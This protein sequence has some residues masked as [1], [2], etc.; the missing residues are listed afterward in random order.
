[1]NDAVGEVSRARPG[2]LRPIGDD[3]IDALRAGSDDFLTTMTV[4][5]ER[6]YLDIEV[7]CN[8]HVNA[9][10]GGEALA[11]PERLVELFLARYEQLREPLSDGRAD[12]VLTSGTPVVQA[13][14]GSSD[15]V[16]P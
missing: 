7:L 4:P 2:A 14:I 3:F 5:R 9:P 1:M 11:R 15:G 12:I 6:P 10:A 13:G 8:P 16:E